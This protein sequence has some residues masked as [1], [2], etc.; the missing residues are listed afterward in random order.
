MTV[1]LPKV[2][3]LKSLIYDCML[4]KAICQAK[5]N[6]DHLLT[7]QEEAFT[8][9]SARPDTRTVFVSPSKS[10]EILDRN[11]VSLLADEQVRYISAFSIDPDRNV[12]RLKGRNFVVR[13]SE[14]IFCI[15]K[16]VTK[17]CERLSGIH[18]E[19]VKCIENVG[20]Y[21]EAIANVGGEQLYSKIESVLKAYCSSTR[22]DMFLFR[23][24]KSNLAFVTCLVHHDVSW[25]LM[26]GIHPEEKSMELFRY[27]LE[28]VVHDTLSDDVRAVV[29][30]AATGDTDIY[31]AMGFSLIGSL[32]AY[33]WSR[34]THYVSIE[35]RIHPST[36]PASGI[37]Q[38]DTDFQNALKEIE[39]LG[40]P[41]HEDLPKNW[42]SL[43]ALSIILR[44][45][46]TQA[47]I[48]DAGGEY[49]SSILPQLAAY[50]YKDLICL[51]LAFKMQST[52]G[53]IIYQPG[54]ITATNFDNEYFDAVT[55]LSVIEHGLNLAVYFR[56]MNRILKTGG[57]LF[58][59]TDYWQD[60]V[61]TDHVFAYGTPSYIFRRDSIAAVI[62]LANECGFQLLEPL[63]LDCVDKVVEWREFNLRYT[64]IYFTLKKIKE[65]SHD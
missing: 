10:D 63:H 44:Y 59:S 8:W 65:I 5:I 7:G 12:N 16:P 34:A 23:N 24:G 36:Y 14:Y 33:H 28:A 40:I 42:D 37:L 61:N 21:K 22:L 54:N 46:N 38:K 1:S 49:Y 29:L 62:R 3:K 26:A 53:T 32:N 25:V 55:C 56:E 4:E 15:T 9:F 52:K 27:I 20:L 47:K 50:N 18:M 30:Q 64:F 13:D 41:Y 58:I 31:S 45:T 43:A 48:L 60:Y 51:N 2:K 57:Y 19:H 6:S 39:Q 17:S 11:I 35:N